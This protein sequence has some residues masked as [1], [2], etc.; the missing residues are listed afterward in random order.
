MF[1]FSK[2][3]DSKLSSI[4]IHGEDYVSQVSLAGRLLKQKSNK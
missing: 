3:A 1:Q 4:Q 2:M